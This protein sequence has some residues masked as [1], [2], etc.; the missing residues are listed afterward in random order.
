[1]P[2]AKISAALIPVQG[3]GVKK[4]GLPATIGSTYIFRLA[5]KGCNHPNRQPQIP[6]SP[7]G[8]P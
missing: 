2:R 6:F 4:A 1:M 3:G 5:C 8:G 7:L